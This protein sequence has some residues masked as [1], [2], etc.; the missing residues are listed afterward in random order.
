MNSWFTDRLTRMLAKTSA[1]STWMTCRRARNGPGEPGPAGG[2]T[3]QATDS[4][5]WAAQR[6]GSAA[7]RWCYW[8]PGV[9]L[10]LRPRRGSSPGARIFMT[11]LP[12]QPETR[13]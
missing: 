4:D 9:A 1:G 12:A 5:A 13:G 7:A 8:P 2:P 6:R 10:R 3:P 11:C